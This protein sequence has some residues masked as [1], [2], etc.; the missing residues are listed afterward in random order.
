MSC[1]VRLARAYASE[2][3]EFWV[4]GD[5]LISMCCSAEECKRK[6]FVMG[7]NA[8]LARLYRCYE[9][10]AR[11]CICRKE[12]DAAL[13]PSRKLARHSGKERTAC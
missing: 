8:V 2:E 13:K 10:K 1:H 7:A 4:V 6:P 3:V 9:E 5:E 12:S 11:L